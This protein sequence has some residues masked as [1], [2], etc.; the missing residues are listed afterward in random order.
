MADVGRWDAADQHRRDYPWM[1]AAEAPAAPAAT[2]VVRMPNAAAQVEHHPGDQGHR[3][4]LSVRLEPIRHMKLKLAT[5]HLGLSAQELITR[6]LDRYIE[7]VAPEVA[8]TLPLSAAGQRPMVAR[9]G[10]SEA[11]RPFAPFPEVTPTTS[12]E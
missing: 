9:A 11:M 6:A 3:K 8:Q 7:T 12:I 4:K 10:G 5:F 2:V 1:P